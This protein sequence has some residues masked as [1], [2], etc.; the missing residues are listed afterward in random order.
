[1]TEREIK[2]SSVYK[3]RFKV[4]KEILFF[5]GKVTEVTDSEI[6][7]I[8]KFGVPLTFKLNEMISCYEQEDK[9]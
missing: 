2:I 9:N 8:D 6:S 5:N 3:F 4:G 1:M 7:F